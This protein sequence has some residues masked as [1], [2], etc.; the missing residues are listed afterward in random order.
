M[1]RRALI[2]SSLLSFV[3]ACSSGS[4][5]APSDASLPDNEDA[6]LPGADADT[7]AP[8]GDADASDPGADADASV[9]PACVPD[10]F[11]VNCGSD[12]CDGSC[13]DCET[14]AYCYEELRICIP[15]GSPDELCAALGEYGLCTGHFWLH[16]D[17]EGPFADP[18]LDGGGICGSLSEG[19]EVGCMAIPNGFPC[20]GLPSIGH[21]AIGDG[22]DIFF[23]CD[24]EG[25]FAQN[26]RDRGEVCKKDRDGVLGCVLDV[27]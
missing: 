2:L 10:C 22:V 4:S 14:G 5:D 12:G 8:L 26:C 19:D 11:G 27:D 1:L 18:C 3:A 6:A 24:E 25:L 7:G 13:G 23:Q 16:C 20:D 21:C 9:E 15:E 17:E